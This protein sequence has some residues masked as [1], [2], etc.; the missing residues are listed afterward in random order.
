V[1]LE[2]IGGRDCYTAVLRK[3][4]DR[5]YSAWWYTDGVTSTPYEDWRWDS[6]RQ[7]KG[8]SLV[9]VNCGSQADL[10]AFVGIGF[11]GL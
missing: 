5:L 9:N 11:L 8:F 1:Q 10:E 3:G 4:E 2:K 7:G 6:L